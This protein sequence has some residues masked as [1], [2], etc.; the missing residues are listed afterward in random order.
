VSTGSGEVSWDI[1][2]CVGSVLPGQ[3]GEAKSTSRAS[4]ARESIPLHTPGQLRA[5]PTFCSLVG[6]RHVSGLS[7]VHST[8]QGVWLSNPQLMVPAGMHPLPCVCLPARF[9]VCHIVVSSCGGTHLCSPSFSQC[10]LVSK[11]LSGGS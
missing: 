7:L 3:E 11:P 5:P 4:C 8:L 2:Q 1:A 6:D 9:C 10:Y